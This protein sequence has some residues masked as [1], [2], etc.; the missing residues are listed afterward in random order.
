MKKILLKIWKGILY[1]LWG[2]FIFISI[3]TLFDWWN[4]IAWLFTILFSVLMLPIV[5]LKIKEVIYKIKPK[6]SIIKFILLYISIIIF[7]YI[8]GFSILASSISEEK[9]KEKAQIESITQLSINYNINDNYTTKEEL[10]IKL[11]YSNIE[12]LKINDQEIKIVNNSLTYNFP[13]NLWVNNI[14]IIWT[15]KWI[16]R[17]FNK[18]ITRETLE[19]EQKRIEQEKE[20]IKL[21]AKQKEL[22]KI[23]QQEEAKKREII[24]KKQ[25]VEQ[26]QAEIKKITDEINIFI[27]L[28]DSY[29][30]WTNDYT[31]VRALEL[32]ANVFWAY[33]LTVD[34]YKNNSN[35][36]IKKLALS[37]ERK[38]SALQKREFPK[39]RKAYVGLVD[40]KMW[41]YNIDVYSKWS[42]NWT[43]ELVWGIFANNKNKLDTYNTLKSMLQLLRFDRAN[44]KW[45]KYDNDYTYW[46]IGSLADSKVSV[47]K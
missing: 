15:N 2:V 18:I 23:K 25:K 26:V 13:L 30:S 3:A 11:N 4:L 29:K 17:K 28:V 19:E 46:D 21:E 6:L 36:E 40:K 31:T 16:E 27:G 12:N 1:F 35:N 43:I 38:T 34:K 41:E 5:Y 10:E 42:L 32:S 14:L 39:M 47:A 9:T 37:L 8:T 24:A 45:Y 20:K 33:A 44:F 7:W 22:D